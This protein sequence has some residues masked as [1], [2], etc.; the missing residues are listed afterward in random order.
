MTKK[1]KK[2]RSNQAIFSSVFMK[3]ELKI[4]NKNIS[5]LALPSNQPCPLKLI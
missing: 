3:E 5:L 4:K 1:K 2:R